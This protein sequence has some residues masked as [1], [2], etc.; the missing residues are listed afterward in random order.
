MTPFRRTTW[1]YG[2]AAAAVG[3]AAVGKIQDAWAYALASDPSSASD[4]LPLYLGAKAVN[5]GL[6]PTDTATI[7]AVYA[8]SDINVT[9]ALFSVLYPPS[10]HVMLLSALTFVCV[11]AGCPPMMHIAGTA[12]SLRSLPSFTASLM[13]IVVSG[14]VLNVTFQS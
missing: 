12:L 4:S 10:L 5:Q 2:A 8:A 11:N 6:D 14:M 13:W 9:K 7:E 3:A 1:A